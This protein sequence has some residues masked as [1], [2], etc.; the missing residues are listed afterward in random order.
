[1]TD[2]ERFII[3]I[4]LIEIF[5]IYVEGV[6][7]FTRRINNNNILRR[8]CLTPALTLYL[9]KLVDKNTIVVCL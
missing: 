4:L 7:I 9:I 2:F 1:M 6:I 3:T 8:D 5:N